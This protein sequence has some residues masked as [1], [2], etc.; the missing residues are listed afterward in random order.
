MKI[1]NER[2]NITTDLTEINR[3]IPEDYD[4]IE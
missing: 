2:R 3:Y 1:R 4:H